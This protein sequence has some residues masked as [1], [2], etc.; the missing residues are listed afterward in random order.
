MKKLATLIIAASFSAPVLAG[1]IDFGIGIEDGYD[2]GHV[3][4]SGAPSGAVVSAVPRHVVDFGPG[5][6]EGHDAGTVERGGDVMLSDEAAP[7]RN[8]L[9]FGAGI[10][11][12][13][14]G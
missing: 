6:D 8:L 5:I 7:R 10:D 9:D 2:T 12:G 3:V 14:E 13:Y 1:G 4:T 11:A